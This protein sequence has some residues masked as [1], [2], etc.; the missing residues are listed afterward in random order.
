M[1]HLASHLVS[2][3]AR[4]TVW[5]ALLVGCGEVRPPDGNARLSPTY[6][7]QIRALLQR[8][9]SCH[10]GADPAGDYD[11]SSYVGLLGPGSD[12]TRNAIAGDGSSLLLDKLTEAKHRDRLLSP[13]AELAPGES[14]EDRREADLAALKTWVV[15]NHLAYFDV[16]VHPPSWVY[17]G[18]RGSRDFHGGALRAVGWSYD[19]CRG[20]HGQDLQGGTAGRSCTTCHEAGPEGCTTCHG[21]RDRTGAAANAPPADLSWNLARTSPG[22]GAHQVHL[23][24]SAW[25]AA[26]GCDDCHRVPRSPGD[27][28]HLF[29]EGDAGTPK[30]DLRAE[31][32][33]G[34]RARGNGS[35]QP[36][37]DRASATCSDVFCHAVHGGTV[38]Q[39]VWNRK[40]GA[41]LMCTG[42]H[43]QPPAKTL[44]GDSHSTSKTCPS[45]HVS[46]YD[47]NGQL[48]LAKHVNGRVDL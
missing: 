15:D 48:D 32:T 2:R 12:T 39:W 14:A 8:C 47:A 38:T 29:D 18:D 28:G 9:V 17:P 16:S 4:F 3:P 27:A 1:S 36:S 44:A 10:A 20:C 26:M 43:G 11:L 13:A 33:F 30:T 42:C 31:V 41:G 19:G 5:L 7:G 37:W 25:R 6:Q 34:A 21:S 22:V 46:A 23:G 24:Q 35:L 45:C 40:P